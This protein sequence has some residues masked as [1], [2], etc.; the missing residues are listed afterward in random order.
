MCSLIETDD[1]S[2]LTTS[3]RKRYP[4]EAPNVDSP[5]SLPD[6]HTQQLP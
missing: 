6:G 3:L 2:T 1:E 5:D 4:K